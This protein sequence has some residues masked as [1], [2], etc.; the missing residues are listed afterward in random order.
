MSDLCWI[1]RAFNDALLKLYAAITKQDVMMNNYVLRSK[2][3]L[4]IYSINCI[5]ST[6]RTLPILQSCSSG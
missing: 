3:L 6:H 2:P 4:W 5:V 1:L